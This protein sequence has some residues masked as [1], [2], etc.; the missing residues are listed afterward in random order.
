MMGMGSVYVSVITIEDRAAMATSGNQRDTVAITSTWTDYTIPWSALITGWGTPIPLDVK[1]IVALD[2]APSGPRP[3]PTSTFGSTTLSSCLD[4]PLKLLLFLEVSTWRPR[5][6]CKLAA[7]TFPVL[8]GA[9]P[10]SS[11]GSGERARLGVLLVHGFTGS[12]A[13]LRP[14]SEMLA[15]RGFTVELLRLP[16]HGTHFRD[17][18]A[19]RYEDWR[20]EVER[21]S[22]LSCK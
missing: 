3:L 17:L 15:R 10:W 9:E 18:M 22:W 19:T 14:L 5:V 7:V 13:S 21:A 8:P 16:G 1:A 11:S 20:G 6:S 4:S 2:F 12:P